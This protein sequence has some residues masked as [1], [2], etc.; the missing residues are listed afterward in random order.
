MNPIRARL[1]LETRPEKP[2]TELR[3][4]CGPSSGSAPPLLTYACSMRSLGCSSLHPN[5]GHLDRRISRRR[6][7]AAAL[8][9]ELL[10]QGGAAGRLDV[11]GRVGQPVSPAAGPFLDLELDER[12]TEAAG[13]RGTHAAVV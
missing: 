5:L 3:R 12:R 2:S 4:P 8:A 10:G 11:R 1:S 7:P 6:F 13:L 9:A